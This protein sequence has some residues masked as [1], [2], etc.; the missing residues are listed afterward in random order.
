[1]R[2][3]LN[4][5]CIAAMLVAGAS[6]QRVT[7]TSASSAPIQ[8]SST[9]NAPSSSITASPKSTMG[10]PESLWSVA[11]SLLTHYFPSTTIT[12]VQSL[13][14]PGTMVIGGS[15]YTIH[16]SQTAT[17]AKTTGT[18]KTQATTSPAASDFGS[19][20]STQ[21]HD[22]LGDKTLSIII[23]V[24]VGVVAL[25]VMGIIFC[26]LHRRRRRTGSFFLR[27]QTP[28]PAHWTSPH[29]DTE[30]F[31]NSSYVTTG[32][33]PY[34]RQPKLPR[35]S[36]M[37]HRG[38]TPPLSMHPAVLHEQ[39]SRSTSDD[40]PFLTPQERS[41]AHLNELEGRQIQHAELDHQEPA[42]RRSSTSIGDSRPPTPF[43]PLM[44]QQMPGPSQKPKIHLN[45]FASA[46]DRE[47][48]DVVSPILPTRSP[49]RRYS[50]IV[51]Y[52]SWDEVS[53]FNFSG[54]ERDR[55]DGGDG[56]RPANERKY[57]RYE[58]A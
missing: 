4:G 15:T 55:V 37:Q 10:I 16:T 12:N 2:R 21:A 54:D 53:E 46:Q 38:P 14:W 11:T 49:E 58:L 34:E 43:S 13:T 51:H 26:L 42:Q 6:A 56:Y 32:G 9:T 1:M 8:S 5:C 20:A 33:T 24:V 18:H 23:G 28:S 25:A 31:G 50:P 19:A 41:T 48:E 29:E 22:Q 30:Q 17:P 39:S 35:V 27:R 36:E 44:M 45:P 57:G 40:N 7:Q 47:A 3:T 52:P